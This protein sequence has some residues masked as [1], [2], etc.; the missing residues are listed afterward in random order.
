MSL[1]LWFLLAGCDALD[2]EDCMFFGGNCQPWV[3]QGL[4]CGASH[5]GFD[6]MGTYCKEDYDP[7]LHTPTL[8]VE[9][10]GRT[11]ANCPD[12]YYEIELPDHSSGQ[13]G[14][15]TCVAIG[16]TANSSGEVR[17]LPVGVIC[18]LTAVVGS[19]QVTCEGYNAAKGE[20]PPGFRW[21][22][23]PDRYI[24]Y[25]DASCNPTSN[26]E[27]T[28]ESE[29]IGT[30]SLSG[31][32]IWAFCEPEL[33]AS[34]QAGGCTTGD[35]PP[36]VQ[37]SSYSLGLICGFHSR[38]SAGSY[39]DPQVMLDWLT[40]CMEDPTFNRY[41]GYID[42]IELTQATVAQE[43][44]CLGESVVDGTCPAGWT[45]MCAYDDWGEAEGQSG[46]PKWCWCTPDSEPMILADTEDSP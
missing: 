24:D 14:L 36:H 37:D 27:D 16:N 19:A 6:H 34:G 11:D 9:S 26:D 31:A 15:H 41:E 44:L 1:L 46:D 13:L 25:V 5:A 28:G 18:G 23:V 40:G 21:R 30:P 7:G 10:A 39:Q 33:P 22:W 3:P 42:I 45:M 2:K 35:C 17:D 38:N 4:L 29:N 43:P 8:G 32:N 12:G 20:C